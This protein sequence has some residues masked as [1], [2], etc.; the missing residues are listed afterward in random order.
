MPFYQKSSN[1]FAHDRHAPS[2][3]LGLL[4]CAVLCLLWHNVDVLKQACAID[5]VYVLLG[6]PQAV[7]AAR[8]R[9]KVAPDHT[10]LGGTMRLGAVME[11]KAHT[12]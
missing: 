4:L 5:A 3:H 10:R 9:C 6:L 7:H 11:A 8:L 2:A 12:N 1:T